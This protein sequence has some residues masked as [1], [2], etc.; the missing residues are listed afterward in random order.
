MKHLRILSVQR[1]KN[2]SR[3]CLKVLLYPSSCEDV[4]QI[5]RPAT[6]QL[7]EPD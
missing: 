2:P 4:Q 1:Q 5:R 7:A 3:L 6:A